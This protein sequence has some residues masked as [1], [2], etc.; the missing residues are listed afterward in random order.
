MPLPGSRIV[1]ALSG[2]RDSVVLL[3]LL[4]E[5]GFRVET[6]HMNF[7]LRDSESDEDERFVANLADALGIPLHIRRVEAQKFAREK[8]IS[9]QEAARVL[10]YRWFD[11]II[12]Q[13]SADAVAVA[14][15]LDDS[16]E[17]V[18]V[19]L[20]RGTGISGLAGIRPVNG[21]II[22][23]LL[24]AKSIEIEDFANAAG[25]RW[26]NDSSNFKDDYLRNRIRHHLMPLLHTIAGEKHGGLENSLELVSSEAGLYAELSDNLRNKLLEKDHKGLYRISLDKLKAYQHSAAALYQTLAPF[27]FNNKQVRQLYQAL[28]RH[29]GKIFR[30]KEFEVYLGSKYLQI[31]RI[32]NSEYTE[33]QVFPNPPEN[34]FLEFEIVEWESQ[35][36][37]SKDNKQAWLDFDT[38]NLP[39]VL[40][41]PKKGDR[42][43]PLGMTK[44]QLLSDFLTNLK[45][46]LSEKARTLLL[47]D[48]HGKII[49]VCGYRIAH[50]NRI[51]T[52]TFK[53]LKVKKK[54]Q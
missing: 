30:S 27:G 28:G 11:E 42:F 23:P 5:A 26:R 37:F 4:L 44:E 32:E 19:N 24:F 43:V 40:R 46:N 36:Q 47:A 3:H 14:H 41:S 50:P 29:A 17:T 25:L 51:Q 49:W 10:R 8:K 31:N 22:R 1:V 45:L 12:V 20:L 53:V 2:G 35:M 15:H 34:C 33:Y 48:A 54:S 16:I 52:G 38:L 9:I 18:F 6:A 7:K 13:Q 39:L 21:K